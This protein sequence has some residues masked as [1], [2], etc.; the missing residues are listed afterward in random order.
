MIFNEK[1]LKFNL[2]LNLGNTDIVI[3][4]IT[5]NRLNN[6]F[7]I[8]Y[9]EVMIKAANSSHIDIFKFLLEDELIDVTY[10][11]NY[12][13]R[14]INNLN[15]LKLISKNKLVDPSVK[16]NE[17]LRNAASSSRLDKVTWLLKDKRVDPS[18][19]DNHALRLADK[20]GSLEIAQVL[21]ENKCVLDLINKEWIETNLKNKKIKEYAINIININ[22]F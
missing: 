17:A 5:N 6:T 12:I 8:N 22:N 9:N 14:N 21:L 13:I 15:I 10:K 1:L 18:D 16:R 11:N 3:D 4:F 7:N 2:N 19:I 20:S